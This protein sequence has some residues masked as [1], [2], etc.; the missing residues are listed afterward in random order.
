MNKYRT[1]ITLAFCSIILAIGMGLYLNEMSVFL[2]TGYYFIFTSFSLWLFSL[3][4]LSHTANFF[5]PSV[6]NVFNEHWP[7]IVVSLTV[8]ICAV[9]ISSPEIKILYDEVNLIATSKTMYM[10][11]GFHMWMVS[12]A[13]DFGEAENIVFSVDK[14]GLFFP[15]LISVCH[16]FLGYDAHNGFVV[17]IIAGF[18]LLLIF[19]FLLIRWFSKETAM[20]GMIVLSAFPI[21]IIYTLSSGFEILNVLFVV[22]SFYLL[23]IFLT[24]KDWRYAEALLLNLVLLAQIRYESAVFAVVLTIILAFS[25]RKPPEYKFSFL[26]F[27]APF[28]FLPV[29][30]QRLLTADYQ[31]PETYTHVFGSDYL[32]LHFPQ[33]LSF[34]SG[35]EQS[36]GVIGIVFYMSIAGLILA[37]LKPFINNNSVSYRAKAMAAAAFSSFS[38]VALIIMSIWSGSLVEPFVSRLSIVFIPLIVFLAMVFIETL[39]ELRRS[40]KI[41]FPIMGLVL[42]ILYWPEIEKNTAVRSI[43][44]YRRYHIVTEFIS[45]NFSEKIISIVDPH[46]TSYSI[47]GWGS[48]SYNVANNNVDSLLERLGD[49]TLDELIVLQNISFFTGE[50]NEL[51]KLSDQYKLEELYVRRFRD[52]ASV[53]IS[54]VIKK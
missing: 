47:H 20:L 1:K 17:N 33:W 24:K 11:H 44:A 22:I 29:L 6:I 12:V 49:N 27:V 53:R 5:N 23:D 43:D 3:I 16:T 13:R 54:K 21:I 39:I 34:F 26:T 36:F 46:V 14:R 9:S 37:I 15:F 35:K 10:E 8:M 40:I 45:S 48:I 38:L 28:L 32:F 50:I 25:L 19:Y 31:L 41:Y 7:A 52:D 2:S 30:W 4:R 42:F 18:S 51:Y